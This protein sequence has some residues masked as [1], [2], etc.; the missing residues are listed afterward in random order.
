M[1]RYSIGSLKILAVFLLVNF[2]SLQA[3][4]IKGYVTSADDDLLAE[5][6]ITIEGTTLGAATDKNGFFYI[7][8]VPPGTYALLCQYIG[9]FPR[10]AVEVKVTK[11]Q[12]LDLDFMLFSMTY[13][14]KGV[15]LEK[16]QEK[17]KQAEFKLRLGYP[18]YQMGQIIV[19][20]YVY[21]RPEHKIEISFW[22]KLVWRM[23]K[24]F[25]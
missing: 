1:K 15:V 4:T 12:I 5:A 17:L 24:L 18:K 20:D 19:K 8:S 16:E 13:N 9:F 6:N 10:R 25:N 23:W 11:D 22:D 2:W 3:A 21:K 14:L 7:N